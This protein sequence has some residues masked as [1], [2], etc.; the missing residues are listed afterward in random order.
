MG[1]A[2]EF[3]YS[4]TSGPRRS[5]ADAY[6]EEARDLFRRL[7]AYTSG[8]NMQ[9][10]RHDLEERVREHPALSIAIG[11]GVGLILGKVVRR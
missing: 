10:M 1:A 2:E 6:L 4:R 9:T 7:A 11:I 3:A 5:G 8:R